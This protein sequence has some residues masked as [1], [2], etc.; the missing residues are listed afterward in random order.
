MPGLTYASDGH[1]HEMGCM[2]VLVACPIVLQSLQEA[3]Q[4]LLRDLAPS[5]FQI[6]ESC[7]AEISV[8]VVSDRIEWPADGEGVWGAP[9]LQLSRGG[10]GILWHLRLLYVHLHRIALSML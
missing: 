7:E 2:V 5:S 6:R 4:H 3:H 9:E 1:V 10:Q 8:E